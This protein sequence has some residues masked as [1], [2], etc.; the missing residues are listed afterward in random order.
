MRKKL[1]I[2]INLL[3][4]AIVGYSVFAILFSLFTKV[5]SVGQQVANLWYIPLAIYTI[6][7]SFI[8]VKDYK[9]AKQSNS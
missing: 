7:I 3:F 1:C 8:N 4:P 6:Y 9:L 5:P 2:L